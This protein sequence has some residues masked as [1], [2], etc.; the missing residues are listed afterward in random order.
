MKL[1][2]YWMLFA[3]GAFAQ[4]GT[5]VVAGRISV[6]ATV[7][8]GV[9]SVQLTN[10]ESGAVY[11]ATSSPTGDF[12]LAAVP[13]GKYELAVSMLGLKTYQQKGIVI[14]KGHRSREA[15]TVAVGG[16]VDETAGGEQ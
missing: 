1:A 15:G 6:P 10:E 7:A 13:A 14:S 11:K 8:M 5:G 9:A 2:V 16:S 4:S 3:A 12:Q